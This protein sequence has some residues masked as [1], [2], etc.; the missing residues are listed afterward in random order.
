MSN[1]MLVCN[2]HLLMDIEFVVGMIDEYIQELYGKGSKKYE[3]SNKCWTAAFWDSYC[4]K[5][6]QKVS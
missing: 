3:A 2:Q 1:N 6:V 5:C 4:N